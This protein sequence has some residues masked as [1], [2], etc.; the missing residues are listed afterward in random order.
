MVIEKTIKVSKKLNNENVCIEMLYILVF[1]I[2]NRISSYI[3]F[4]V[5]NVLSKTCGDVIFT[6]PVPKRSSLMFVQKFDQITSAHSLQDFFVPN[7]TNHFYF[8]HVVL[9]AGVKGIYLFLRHFVVFQSSSLYNMIARTRESK[10]KVILMI[11]RSYLI[12]EL[13]LTSTTGSMKVL[14]VTSCLHGNL[15][16]KH[17]DT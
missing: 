9:T 4:I 16:Y 10:T 5:V 1:A 17:Q 8:Q 6:Y 3:P 11:T 15:Q 2:Q 7:S 14:C 13:W 12:S